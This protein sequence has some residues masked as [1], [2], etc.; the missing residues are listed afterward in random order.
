[1][2]LV[3]YNTNNNKHNNQ[4]ISL[5]DNFNYWMIFLFLITSLVTIKI[6]IFSRLTWYF[7]IPF[8][9]MLPNNSIFYFK[10]HKILFV[11]SFLITNFIVYQTVIFIFRPKWG[12]F[13]PYSTFF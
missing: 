5:N 13:F 10:T 6:P 4:S 9:Y 2:Y 11:I 1:M 12:G 7:A 8:I 3:V